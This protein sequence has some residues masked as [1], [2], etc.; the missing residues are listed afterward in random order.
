MPPPAQAQ[1]IAPSAWGRAARFSGASVSPFNGARPRLGTSVP[2]PLRVGPA[3]A[4]DRAR[5]DA[6]VLGP[7]GGNLLQ[8]WAWAE[9]KH[10]H[11]WRVDRLLASGADGGVAGVLHLLSR[12][13]PGGVLCFAYAPRGP[14]VVPGE[15]GVG[16][17]VALIEA[18]TRIAR[19]RRAL[20]LKLDPEW[21]VDDPH[22]AA[23]RAATRLR[24]SAY[25]IQHRLTYA[26]D[27]G[28][29]AGAVLERVKASTRR[30][31]RRAQAG[32]VG[33]E[34][35]HDPAAAELFHPLLGA[36]VGRNGFVARDLAYHRAV[37]RHLPGS[38]AVATLIARVEGVPVAG[39]VAV[40][41][42]PRL[43]YL[44]GGSSLEHAELQ[45][46]YLLH[47]RA[48]E[49][50]LAQGCEV[51]DMWGVP[52]HEDPAAPGAGYYEFKRRWN[53]EVLRH[54]RCQEAPL[55]PRL[56]PLPRVAE[57]LA[58]RGRPLLS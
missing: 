56:G 29:G 53:G 50:G 54:L 19:R 35:H 57:R 36:T 32:G 7:A 2:A 51:Y 23:V 46:N 10:E 3:L 52:N 45:P 9:L 49:W 48:I 1:G 22:A 6:F 39:M 26:V 41:A 11:G 13:A 21:G 16:P 18:A 42:G 12:L 37:L 40:A 27:L 15:A 20:V 28:G 4:G 38:C 55:W 24:D 5:W 43:V 8:T 34:V 44:F 33:V 25:D 58:L 17:A 31:I 47:W 30:N 14:A